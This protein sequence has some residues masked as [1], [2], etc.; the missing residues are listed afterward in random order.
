MI[1][2]TKTAEYKPF[3]NQGIMNLQMNSGSPIGTSPVLITPDLSNSNTICLVVLVT[4]LLL[5]SRE[6]RCISYVQCPELLIKFLSFPS[7]LQRTEPTENRATE[8]TLAYQ[9]RSHKNPPTIWMF[10]KIGVPHGTPKWMVY[11][12]KPY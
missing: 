8:N 7:S 10:P 11:N 2:T 6:G 1:K 9:W 4:T 12:G 5:A 3:T